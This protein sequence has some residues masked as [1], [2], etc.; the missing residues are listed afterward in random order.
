MRAVALRWCVASLLAGL[1]NN[2]VVA[3]FE[4]V[5][6]LLLPRDGAAFVLAALTAVA[7]SL[8]ALSQLRRDSSAFH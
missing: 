2:T 6:A 3:I 5:P 4:T 7:A 1:G 8:G